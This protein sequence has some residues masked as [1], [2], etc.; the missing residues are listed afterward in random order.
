[1]ASISYPP[2]RPAA[3]AVAA[4]PG[5]GARTV[6][7]ATATPQA[8]ATQTGMWVCVCAVFMCFAAFVSALVVRE[9]TSGDWRHLAL[10]LAPSALACL[11]LTLRA[12]Q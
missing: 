8:A 5:A 11:E 3:E 12:S 4:I 9:G 6:A 7:Q 2:A 10:P 1:M